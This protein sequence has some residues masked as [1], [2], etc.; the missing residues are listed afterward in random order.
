MLSAYIMPGYVP[1]A[2][3]NK[4][5]YIPSKNCMVRTKDQRANF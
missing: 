4:P 5:T 3:R 2:L 1:P